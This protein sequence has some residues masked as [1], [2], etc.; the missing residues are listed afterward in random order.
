MS[1]LPT[2]FLAI[3]L[4]FLLLPAKGE[5]R[6]FV[7]AAG[8]HVAIPARVERILAANEGAAVFVF[9]LAPEKLV[10]W[11]QPLAV[12]A[13]A[14]LP[15]KFVRLPVTGGLEADRVRRW[16]P[17]LIVALGV[18]TPAVRAQADRIARET[19]VA[20]IFLDP[21]F[22][23]MPRQL[24][25]IGRV[26]GAQSR[27]DDLSTQAADMINR[28]RGTLLTRPPTKRP[29]VYYGLG[30]D[31][32]SAGPH[33]NPAIDQ[34][35]AINVAAEA[36]PRPIARSELLAWNPSIVIAQKKSFYNALRRDPD[37]ASLAAVRERRIYL[38]PHL[39]FGWLDQ[40]DGINR[41]VGLAWLSALFYPKKYGQGFS[42]TAQ[43]FY[44]AFYGVKLSEAALKRLLRGTGISLAVQPLASPL[45][46]SPN[47]PISGPKLGPALAPMP[48]LK[49]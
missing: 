39:P 17:D 16:H 12:G 30:A 7:D 19:G 4:A 43:S 8:R 20:T 1:R 36:G 9:T 37:F 14:Y 35:G 22:Q 6:V 47:A 18:P 11:P 42:V 49:Y 40:P 2:L 24:R 48:N 34:A 32:L 28:L 44:D 27:G 38:A 21:G 3:L 45:P 46:V 41:L 23:K 26:I 31:G 15:R 25:R 29:R 10:G 5:A 33:R 13:R